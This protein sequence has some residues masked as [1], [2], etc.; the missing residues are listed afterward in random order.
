MTLT[1]TGRRHRF[2]FVLEEAQATTLLRAAAARNMHPHKFASRLMFLVTH[3]NLIDA[4]L[5]DADALD[6]ERRRQ[7]KRRIN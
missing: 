5:D 6:N 2:Y 1:D 3:D 4:V 7:I